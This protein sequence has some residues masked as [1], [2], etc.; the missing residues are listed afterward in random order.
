M[1]FKELMMQTKLQLLLPRKIAEIQ[2][3]SSKS[4]K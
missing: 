2:T 1:V 4:Q 3:P